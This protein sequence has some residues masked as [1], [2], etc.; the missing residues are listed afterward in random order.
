MN[1]LVEE[2]PALL[3]LL[4][5]EAAD[6][7]I[8]ANSDGYCMKANGKACE[9]TGFSKEEIY[10]MHLHDLLLPMNSGYSEMKQLKASQP[11]ITERVLRRKDG[12]LVHLEISARKLSD[13]T[14]IGIA[15]DITA[16]KEA[17]RKLRDSEERF[18]A[19]TENGG[20]C[21]NL[22]CASGEIVYVNP[23]NFRVLGY[24]PEEMIGHQPDEFI[25]PEDQAKK[26]PAF[27]QLLEVPGQSI[28]AEWRMRHK[29]GRWIWLEGHSVN[30]LHN[31]SVNAIVT[32]FRDISEKKEAEQKLREREMLFRALI[33]NNADCLA[34]ADDTGAI[35]YISDSVERYF[36]F[37]VE[38]VMGRRSRDFLVA[39][40][41]PK[42]EADLKVL[43]ANPGKKMRAE[44]RIRNKNGELM[45]VE[46]DRVNMLDNPAVK[47]VVINF[48]DVTTRRNAEEA[49]REREESLRLVINAGRMVTFVSDFAT[50]TAKFSANLQD[51]FGFDT[52][53]LE[54]TSLPVE[55]IHPED[56][57]L[58]YHSVENSKKGIIEDLCFRVI[59]PDNG[60]I[61][62]VERRSQSVVNAAGEITGLR[63]VLIDVTKTKRAE[64]EA[65]KLSQELAR[66]ESKLQEAQVIASLASWEMDLTTYQMNWSDA[67]F[68]VF[69]VIKEEED[70]AVDREVA[71]SGRPRG[72]VAFERYLMTIHP[73]DRLTVKNAIEQSFTTMKPSSFHYRMTRRDGS[74]RHIFE[75]VLF[76]YSED[77]TAIRSYGVVQDI[78]EQKWVEERL[79][80]ALKSL[81]KSEKKLKEAQAIACMGSW[82]A[83]FTTLKTNWSD[84]MFQIFGLDRSKVEP[85]LEAY[86]ERIHPDDRETATAIIS[87]LIKDAQ[88]ATFYCRAIRPTGEVRYIY[89]DCRV[90]NDENGNPIRLYGII[91]DITERK[92]A[93]ETLVQTNSRLEESESLLKESQAIAHLGHWKVNFLTNECLWSDESFRILG[94]EPEEVT[95][96]FDMF[97]SFIHP[98]DHEATKHIMDQSMV[99][100]TDFNINCRIVRKDGEIR[101]ISSV[102]RYMKNEAGVP[103][104]L[105]GVMQDVTEN[106]ILEQNLKAINKDL[107]T[108]IYKASHDLRGPLAS[109]S[110]LINVFRKELNSTSDRQFLGMIEPAIQKLDYTLSGLVQSM[111]IKDARGNG[112]LVDFT[113]LIPG[114][115]ER[116]RHYQGFSRMAITTDI[117]F[118]GEFRSSKFVLESVFQNLVENAIKYQ[119]YNADHGTLHIGIQQ[120][121]HELVIKCADSGIGIDQ[122]LQDK[123]FDMYFRA[124]EVASGSGLGLYLVK[125]GIERLGGRITVC[126]EKRKGTTFVIHLPL[127]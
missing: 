23:A 30:L 32:N 109:I 77:G 26:G 107:E 7:I 125:N 69:Q 108:F 34:L 38:D 106:R 94:L 62:W 78:T 90:E 49:L 115:I 8:I 99:G 14:I 64:L 97:L 85:G 40:D 123:I 68:R 112:E 48:R 124:T 54:I 83:D 37:T 51:V 58:V 113:T 19:M 39:E 72:T 127:N 111:V 102:A 118:T 36:G 93:Q 35:T 91:H 25:H 27:R 17:S 95:P 101:H 10:G 100:F 82:D 29:D 21:I 20:D 45:W 3:A 63:G 121:G 120:I 66:S 75:S 105:Y 89:T 92:Q 43:R 12:T 117:A 88:P 79:I 103:V 104:G 18:R 84:E 81:E 2:T 28:S 59:R 22:S 33:E 4:F 87:Q 96:S 53:N 47:A 65:K 116:Y 46:V 110:G 52:Q 71:A 114:V 122:S 5:E 86:M 1:T 50:N 57:K 60:E 98:D 61:N 73:D 119:D 16:K 11:L 67:M 126:S 74:Q 24:K 31:P 9:I 56:I 55:S 70:E 76:E 44:W 15:R 42:E 13:G 80:H 41:I 6:G